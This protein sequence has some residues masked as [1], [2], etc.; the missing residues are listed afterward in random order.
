MKKI[1]LTSL[2]AILLAT[3]ANAG[4]Y[5]GGYVA[6][7]QDEGLDFFKQATLDATVGYGFSG[8]IRV[9]LDVLQANLWDGDIDT[10]PLPS[11]DVNFSVNI[12]AGFLKGLYDIK[13][14]GPVTPYVGVGINPFAIGYIYNSDLEASV[15]GL[16]I[17]GAFIGGISYALNDS[18]SLDLQYNRV[19]N[20]TWTRVGYSGG[21][22]TR[23]HSEGYDLVKLGARYN[24]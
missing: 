24:F 10:Y 7:A 1:V 17:D 5:V 13:I 19:F 4:W 8:G 15:G 22:T 12:G 2:G 23:S 6:T 11:T 14:D 9:E 3:A 21:S 20:Y 16:S 18:L